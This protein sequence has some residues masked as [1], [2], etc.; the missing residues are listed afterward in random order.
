MKPDKKNQ[1]LQRRV[2]DKKIRG[3]LTMR[4]PRPS[5]GWIKAVRGSLGMTLKNLG[6]RAGM[7]AANVTQIESR[8]VD[9]KVSLEVL[10]KLADAMGCELTYA[11]VPKKPAS[12]LE[13][14]LAR[15]ANLAAKK[16]IESVAHS[17]SLEG[18]GLAPEENQKMIEQLAREMVERN[19]SRIWEASTPAK[20]KQKRPK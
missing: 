12:S 3:L 7:S 11:L 9:M 18:Q 19:D 16:I 4:E 14:I 8:E 15:E 10:A 17:M 1:T 2:I 6:S 20:A 5:A 13:E